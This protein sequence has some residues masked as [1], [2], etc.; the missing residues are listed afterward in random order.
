[1]PKR[2]IRFT[3]DANYEIKEHED[4]RELVIL[5]H[6]Y[7][8]SG[9]VAYRMLESCVGPHACV[10]APDAPFPIPQKTTTGY[11][12]AFT[13]YFF[14]PELDVYL[15]DMSIALDYLL[16][17]IR[18]LGMEEIP[19]KVVGYS[20]GGYLAPFLAL[21]LKN[22]EKVVGV[23]CRFRS[24]V[25]R[26]PLPF[27]LDAVHGARDVL[28]D[29]E[30]AQRCHR[31]LTAQGCRGE[32]HLLSNSGHGISGEAREVLTRLLSKVTD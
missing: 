2:T 6:G 1:M 31:E 32:F 8:Q 19:K 20:Q 11:R 25:L 22:V 9:E 12:F 5:L 30:R 4:P 17:L 13:W 26:G 23:N 16:E 29:P 18:E 10:L 15:Y 21:R 14:D 24:E 27:S 3:W 28:V 7:Q